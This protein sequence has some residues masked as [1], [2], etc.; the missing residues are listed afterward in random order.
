MVATSTVYL[1]FANRDLDNWIRAI[2]NVMK[3][4]YFFMQLNWKL[5][6]FNILKWLTKWTHSFVNDLFCEPVSN[7]F[8]FKFRFISILWK[9]HY[10][11]VINHTANISLLINQCVFKLF[12]CFKRRSLYWSFIDTIFFPVTIDFNTTFVI[13]CIWN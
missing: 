2:S 8:F 6:M 12:H 7:R 11:H 9:A 1:D 4:K 10:G 5:C 3:V 13:F